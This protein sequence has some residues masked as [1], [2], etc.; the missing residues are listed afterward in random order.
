MPQLK[1]QS[2]RKLR[3]NRMQTR[4]KISAGGVAHRTNGGAIEIALIKTSS[5]GRWQLPKGIIDPGETPEIAALRE[6]REEAGIDCEILEKL[7]VIDYWFVDR[8]GDE[9]IRTHKYVHFFNMRYITGDI[10]DHDDEV[11][12]SRWVEIETAVTMLAFSTEKEIVEKVRLI[13]N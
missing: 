13:I 3:I 4:E 5:E 6:V 9:P 2:S 1:K 11:F 8:F 12:E 10:A 7:D